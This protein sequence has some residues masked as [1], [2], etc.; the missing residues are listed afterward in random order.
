MR[1]CIVSDFF[2]PHYHGG[3]ERRYYEIAKRLVEKGHSVDVICMKIKGVNS[4]ENID[5]I[6]VR[7][8]GPTIKKPPYRNLF[9]FIYFILSAFWWIIRHDYDIIDAQTY[10]PLIPAFFAAK[11]KGIK[12]IGTIHDVSSGEKDQWLIFPRLAS[13]FE[14]ILV[15]LPYNRIITVSNY[16]K[17]ALI[18]N[19]NVNPGRIVVIHNG[20][21]IDLIDSI[22]IDEK[23]DN[24]IIYVGR[25]APHKHVDDLIQSVKLLETDWPKIKLR[26][27]GHGTEKDT[28]IEL[29]KDLK[30]DKKVKF[31]GEI[32]YKDVIMEIKKSNLL[33]LPSTRE[34]FGM[35]L[36]EAGACKIPV[37]AYK[38]GGVVEVVENG[39]NG[40]LVEPRNI[41]EF[42]SKIKYLINNKKIAIK[43]GKIGRKRVKN[44]FYWNKIVDQI[45]SIYK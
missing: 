2:T 20:V 1:I 29:V 27:I 45:Y 44:L 11:I 30:L 24:S 32:V 21:D 31:L 39:K 22:K 33:V 6:K 10:V 19:Y 14:K 42:S 4:T 16:T 38:S 26:I 25:L 28:L 13:T 40:F 15:K 43:M 17:K 12:V 18:K 37:V 34:G 5:G 36:A 23:Y 7:H 35:V 9:D 8:V 41:T 3:G